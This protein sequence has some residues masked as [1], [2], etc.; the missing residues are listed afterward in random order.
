MDIRQAT[1]DDL[2][3][4]QNANLL[5]LPE[6]YTFKYYL[7]HAL[8]WPEL[9]YVAVDPKGRIVGYILAKMEEEPSDT[10][11]GH[12][13]SISVL[14]PYRRLGLANKL[15]KQSQEAMVAHYDAHHITLHVRKSN[16]AAISLYRDTL[17]FEVHGMEKSYYA[18]GEDAYG[19]RYVF[20]KPEESLKE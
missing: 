7:Y 19:M 12:V 9:S 20:K 16:R 4:M 11:S 3:G 10:P 2:L 17:G 18:D 14:R 6:N 13:T 15:M 1:I 8:T 5:N